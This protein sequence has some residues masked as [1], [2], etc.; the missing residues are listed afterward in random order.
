VSRSTFIDVVMHGEE[1]D[2]SYDAA[3]TLSLMSLLPTVVVYI[4][5]LI[6]NFTNDDSKQLFAI[7]KTLEF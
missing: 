2:Y 3:V 5:A 6:R 7:P 4:R 1:H